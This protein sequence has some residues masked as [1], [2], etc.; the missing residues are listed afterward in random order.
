MATL[1]GTNLLDS[2][3]DSTG[4]ELNALVYATL[5][6]KL[7]L[8]VDNGSYSNLAAATFAS[9]FSTEI[10]AG[11]EF[12]SLSDAIEINAGLIEGAPDEA[13]VD[14]LDFP[15]Y[16]APAPIT[17]TLTSSA[18]N[19]DEGG[20]VDFTIAALEGEDAL[21]EGT[22]IAYSISGIQTEDTADDLTGTATVGA[23]GTATVTITLTEDLLTEGEETMTFT[24]GDD[25]IDVVVNDTSLTD[26]NDTRTFEIA[27]DATTVTEGDEVVFTVTASE[28]SST[29]QT[30]T[31][32]ISGVELEGVAAPATPV[33]DLGVLNGTVVIA[34][35][36][37]TGTFTL[38]PSDDGTTEGFEAFK[39]TLLNADNTAGPATGSILI[40]DAP[41]SGQSYVLTDG[42]DEFTGGAGNDTFTGLF[43]NDETDDNST[44]TGLDDLDGG[45]GNDILNINNISPANKDGEV[46]DMSIATITDIETIN[47]KA[48]AGITDTKNAYVAGTNEV[49]FSSISGLTTIN[50]TKSTAALVKAADT[51]DVNVSGATGLISVRGG[52][53]VSVNDAT[54]AKA[55]TIGDV[56]AA[57]GN[58]AGTI[59]VTDTDNSGGDNDI[60]VFG[61]TDVTVTASSEAATGDIIVGDATGG[62]ATGT[63]SVTQNIHDDGAAGI[64]NS[65]LPINV[66]GGSSVDVNIN[67]T[68]TADAKADSGVLKLS[69]TNVTGDGETTDVTVTQTKD[70]NVFTADT[71]AQVDATST[72]TFVDMEAGE[73]TTVNGL[74]FTAATSLEAEDVAA[75]FANLTN[76]DTQVSGGPTANGYYTNAS[77]TKDWV[78]GAAS[79]ATVT[80]TNSTSTELADDMT[81][82]DTAAAG[83]VAENTTAGTAASGGEFSTGSINYGTASVVD[84]ATGAITT[85]TLDGFA[86]ASLGIDAD[87]T[88]LAV[89]LDALTTLNVSNNTPDG[90]IDVA[91][92]STT[93]ALNVDAITGDS[94]P[95]AVIN[96]DHDGDDTVDGSKTI[97]DLTI[98]ATGTASAFE[99]QADVLENLTV[100]AA[101]DLDLSVN[102]A[103]GYA[104]A[105]LLTVDVNGAGAVDLGVLSTNSIALNSFDASD[106]TGGVTA[107]V[108]TDADTLTGD[109]TEYIF[110]DGNDVVTLAQGA[111]TASDSNIT[112]GAGDDKLTIATGTTVS[113]GTLAGGT[114]TNTIAMAAADAEV[115]DDGTFEGKMSGFSK[116]SLGEV[117]TTADH[118]VDLDMMD[119]ISHVIS[120]GTADTVEKTVVTTVSTAAGAT[121]NDSS[122]S[123][124]VNGTTYSYDVLDADTQNDALIALAGLIAADT[125]VASAVLSTGDNQTLTITATTAGKM[126]DVGT[127]TDSDSTITGTNEI[128]SSEL[129]I[130]SMADNGTL[131]LTADGLGATV[132]MA[133]ASGDTDT[134]NILTGDEAANVGTVVVDDVETIDVTTTDTFTDTTG[135][136]DGNGNNI[137][138]GIDDSNITAT[139]A[140]SAD[141][142]ETINVDGAG[143]LTLNTDSTVLTEVD[144]SDLT[145]VLSYIADGAAAGTTVTGGSAADSLTAAGSNDVLIGGAGNDTITGADLTE[146]TG[147]DGNDTFS[148]NSPTNVN[149]YSTITDFSTGDVIDLADG[150]IFISSAIELGDTAVFQDYANATA[151]A[152]DDHA[153]A[154]LS[155]AGDAAWFQY[156][157]NTYIIESGEATGSNVSDDYVGGTDSIIKLSGLVDLST[158]SY[159]MTNG[160]IEMA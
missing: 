7:Q 74:T 44:F 123:L 50:T 111:G 114:G 97:T 69:A 6:T 110:S 45:A 75:A 81:V 23:D 152:I 39:V 92:T 48:V 35:G 140:V 94:T 65:A 99:L 147:G 28:V 102:A 76:D 117:A 106:N 42:V 77:D 53:D 100:D 149:A 26:T 11:T 15:D 10:N 132:T 127:L 49:D 112:L 31:Y 9:A 67:G 4:I 70:V 131:E 135:A 136:T 51:Q 130:N 142:A 5:S 121:A 46:F 37:T 40:Q 12:F 21:V 47:I 63:V 64:D 101:V 107:T 1:T 96:L 58:P 17:F 72:V 24:A 78:S 57:T 144:A 159:N 38:T 13:A 87:E 98:G 137:A 62:T 36:E 126:M 145:G 80:F 27:G 30:L 133:D 68:S 29:E 154:D 22:E 71:V 33:D 157:N 134:F 148:I 66:I 116:L 2:I 88:D 14:A 83:N 124:E 115:L 60:K 85:I 41:N 43:D 122:L 155:T 84:A 146:M 86:S 125:D 32:T 118:T 20:S 25:T 108:E 82:S 129:F 34:A 59:T 8:M 3:I 143:D 91:T 120:A 153:D 105:A 119:D 55:I 128:T 138:D 139:L 156:D 151:K 61:G 158:A 95:N 113:N 18:D 54:T 103:T 104:N 90:N 141:A 73:T 56:A 160:T 52:K 150:G 93:L 19:V 16:E 79:G 89:A 109:I